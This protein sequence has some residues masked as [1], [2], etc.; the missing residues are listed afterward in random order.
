ME[1]LLTNDRLSERISRIPG[2]DERVI[3]DATAPPSGS[4]ANSPISGLYRRSSPAALPPPINGELD[5]TASPIAGLADA[6]SREELRLDVDGILPQQVA[7]G[8]IYRALN[9]RVDWIAQLAPEGANAWTGTVWYKKGDVGSFPYTNIKIQVIRSGSTAPQG[10]KAIFSGGGAPNA[11]RFFSYDSPRFRTLEFE[12]DHVEGVDPALQYDTHSHPNRPASLPAENLTIPRV[13][14]RAGF[15]VKVSANGG[16]IPAGGAGANARWSDAEMHDAMQ[17]YWSRFANRAQWALWVF[18][19]ALHED[20]TGLGGIMF[21][22]IGGNHRQGTAIFT[23]SFISSPPAGDPDGAAWVERMK[24]WC[25]CH[26]MGHAFN[27]AHSWQKALGT[28]W[29]PLANEPEARSFMNYPYDVSG[30]QTAFFRDFHYSFSDDELLFMRHAPEEFVQ[31]G[32]ADWFDHH[33]F[34]QASV[35]AEPTFRLELRAYREKVKGVVPAPMYEFLEPV[36]LELKLINISPR[37]QVVPAKLLSPGHDLTVIVKRKGRAAR[38]VVPFATYCWQPDYKA[39]S[40][41]ESLYESVFVSVGQGGWEID[42]PGYY[43]V[44]VAL[45]TEHE[46]IVSNPLALRVAPPES[47]R[48]EYLAQDFFSEAV[49]RILTFDGSRVMTSGNDAMEEVASQLP[50]RNVT[51]HV[52]VAQA[53]SL[54]KE[55]KELAITG[56]SARMDS[57]AAAGATITTADA[58]LDAASELLDEVLEKPS[59]AADTLGNIDLNYYLTRLSNA[60]RVAGETKEAVGVLDTLARGLTARN[61]A[62]WVIDEVRRMRTELGTTEGNGATRRTSKRKRK[63]S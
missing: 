27:L 19:A 5:L 22:D 52:R 36:V 8:T 56:E 9:S 45:H 50:D 53:S 21:D 55:Y 20:G 16:P 40:P 47:N 54:M 12:F 32:N 48:E 63:S 10:V 44:H 30:G 35:L 42:E 18:Y 23:D 59:N 29:I 49:G 33:A 58:D 11:E 46:D 57:A 41:G 15:D 1:A 3:L 26:E 13:F 34:E 17:T 2:I 4:A 28:P 39:L 61:V 38:Q 60:F 7:S 43:S 31:M 62:G 6:G 51:L 24:F 14:E 25:A 37:P